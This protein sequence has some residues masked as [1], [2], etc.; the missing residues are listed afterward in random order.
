[1][2]LGCDLPTQ[3]E[4]ALGATNIRPANEALTPSTV[5]IL[6]KKIP[7]TFMVPEANILITN[8]EQN[9]AVH[10]GNSMLGI[11]GIC[12]ERT[13][14]FTPYVLIQVYWFRFR[15]LVVVVVVNS[16][17]SSNSRKVTKDNTCKRI[18]K[19]ND[20]AL[21]PSPLLHIETVTMWSSWFYVSLSIPSKKYIRG[22]ARR[23]VMLLL[24]ILVA[25]DTHTDI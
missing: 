24:S 5:S 1:M 2:P 25:Y 8:K 14:F 4:T 15:F 21:M 13:N 18:L 9:A 7:Q 17:S 3:C 23:I 16:S 11:N 12:H 10:F 20:F 22:E 19:I 6:W